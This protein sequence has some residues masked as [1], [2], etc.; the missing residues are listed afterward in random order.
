MRAPR[1]AW[2]MLVSGM[3][4]YFV[5]IVNRTALG[6]AGVEALDRFGIE[7]AW[8]SIL[9][10]A[11]VATYAALQLPAGA[12]LDRWGARR[13]MIGGAL[14]MTAGTVLLAF[15]TSLPLAI[16]ARVLIGAGDAPIFISACRL[17]PLWFPARRVPVLVQVTG[18]VGQAGQLATSIP[19]AWMLKGHG[20]SAT[21]AVLAAVTLA[22][23]ALASRGIRVPA[24][25]GERAAPRAPASSLRASIR[26]ASRPAGTRLG[27][28]TH[29]LSLC[30]ANTVALLWGVPFF[31]TTQGLT[32]PEASALLMVITLTKM[33]AGPLA[34]AFTAR[35][36]LRRSWLVLGSAVATAV[37]WVAILVPD[38]PRPVWELGV[39]MAVIG[40]GGP[41]SLIALDYA[42]TFGPEE[43]MGTATGFVNVGGFASTI[44]G[45]VLVGVTL[46]AVSPEGAT[47]YTLGEYR[48][49]FA[50]LLIPWVMGV[51]GVLRNRRLAR[52]DMAAE[53]VH[54]PPIR[55]VIQRYRRR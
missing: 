31:V 3:A 5:A 37:A 9:A 23:A 44:L 48:I 39:L 21:F 14:L 6:V 25:T 24:T 35:H 27:F 49:A 52:L 22:T 43:A 36:P 40:A 55:D 8:L 51:A 42:R 7:A 50:T 11:Q 13:L 10:I 34:G 38:T 29:F 2:L 32:L 16:L 28:W 41:V 30:S 54:V 17:I 47:A 26:L 20:W 18:L 1:A 12:L 33:A 46:Q 45:I 19:V 4:L 53:G 15:T